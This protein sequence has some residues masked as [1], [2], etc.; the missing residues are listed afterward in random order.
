V[1]A[2]GP[3]SLVF[4]AT[5]AIKGFQS[6]GPSVRSALVLAMEDAAQELWRDVLELTP[7]SGA[8]T[9]KQSI[10]VQPVELGVDY[11]QVGI[12]TALA[13]A[14]PVELGS[15][16]HMP[17]YEP[18]RKWVQERKLVERDNQELAG[19]RKGKAKIASYEKKLD[20]KVQA[21][22]FKIFRKGT[23]A[24]KMFT[25]AFEAKSASIAQRITNAVARAIDEGGR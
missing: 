1:T 11:V 17:P 22:R 4:D 6:M 23:P 9:L 16:P 24:R 20:R 7:S 8:G 15:R 10:Q 5:A 19:P 18:I 14:L 13:Y 3:F 12:G 25:L 2:A 21:I